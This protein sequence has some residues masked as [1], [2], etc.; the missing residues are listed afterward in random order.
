MPGKHGL[1]WLDTQGD[2]RNPRGNCALYF[3]KRIFPIGNP[4]VRL[5]GMS[6]AHRDHDET[7]AQQHAYRTN[8]VCNLAKTSCLFATRTGGICVYC[9]KPD[10]SVREILCYCYF[11]LARKNIKIRNEFAEWKECERLE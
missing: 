5:V 4:A 7:A 1:R 3:G 10:D 2:D 6:S 9:K 11:Q 8:Q